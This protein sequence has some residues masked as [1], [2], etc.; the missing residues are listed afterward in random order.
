MSLADNIMQLRKQHGY[1]QEELADKL[2]VSRQAVSKWES[3]Q[4]VPDLDKLVKMSEI[5]SVSTDT[6]LKND[7][8]ESA[9]ATATE[10][11]KPTR[12]VSKAEA[13]EYLSAVHATYK[14]T[15]LGV[16]LCI[17]SPVV[18]F[19]LLGVSMLTDGALPETVAVL[20]GLCVLLCIVA[21]AV[22][23]FVWS[24]LKTAPYEYLDKTAFALEECAKPFVKEHQTAMRPSYLRGNI[25]GVC[26]C[27]LSPI[28]LLIAAIST[29][30][31]VNEGYVLFALAL[32]LAIVSVAAYLFV[33]VGVPTSA[34]QRLLK[35]G[36]FGGA[37]SWKDVISSV[38]WLLVVGA[39]LLWSFT[40]SA[41]A[42]SWIVWPLAGVLYAVIEKACK[43][44]DERDE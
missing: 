26:L 43:W 4:S 41:W 32:L 31:G 1:S 3:G 9:S 16:L 20:V 11:K 24:G 14:K 23:I 39:Y 38:Y 36:E 18:M 5:F 8:E 29:E 13:E 28:A 27:V 33:V 37:K 17:L 7:V 22:G 12:R 30:F 40:T 34:T 25:V 15:A 2:D 21:V 6:L 10:R 44:K 19:V 35:E 42:I